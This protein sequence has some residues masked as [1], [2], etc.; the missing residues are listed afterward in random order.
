MGGGFAGGAAALRTA[1]LAALH[2]EAQISDCW[3][4][5]DVIRGALYLT[6][7]SAS[8]AQTV[9]ADL[10]TGLVDARA[11]EARA[12]ESETNDNDLARVCQVCIWYLDTGG[13]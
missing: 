1:M 4:F 6:I 9:G 2:G 8:H 7:V 10:Y 11:V 5:E 12:L 13:E 3:N